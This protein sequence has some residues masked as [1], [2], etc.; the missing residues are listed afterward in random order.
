MM[1]DY[2]EQYEHEVGPV[3]NGRFIGL[4]GRHRP[5]SEYERLVIQVVR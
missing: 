3:P 4:A 1:K 2:G 5:Y